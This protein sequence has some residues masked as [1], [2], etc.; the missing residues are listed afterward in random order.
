[1]CDLNFNACRFISV[2]TNWYFFIYLQII[3]ISNLDQLHKIR[4][5]GQ[6]MDGQDIMQYLEVALMGER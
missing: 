5:V 2:I 3:Q 6:T 4:V 1:M